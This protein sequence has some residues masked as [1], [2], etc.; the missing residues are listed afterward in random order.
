MYVPRFPRRAVRAEHGKL[1]PFKI[2]SVQIPCLVSKPVGRRRCL[3]SEL[4]PSSGTGFTGWEAK[5]WRRAGLALCYTL[6]R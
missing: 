6:V 3:G 2:C 1:Y 4:V 5:R